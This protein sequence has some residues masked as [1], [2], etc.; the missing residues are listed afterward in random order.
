MRRPGA[1]WHARH[2]GPLRGCVSGVALAQGEYSGMFAGQAVPGAV[3]A[4]THARCR[5]LEV[6]RQEHTRENVKLDSKC[7]KEP[8]R[9][10]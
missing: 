8:A 7:L 3:A 4:K 6:G 1:R 9:D 2:A 5:R 10:P